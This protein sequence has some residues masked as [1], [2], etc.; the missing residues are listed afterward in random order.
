MSPGVFATTSWS[1]LQALESQLRVFGGYRTLWLDEAGHRV[2]H[3]EPDEALESEG[4]TYVDTVLH[5]NAEELAVLL[6]VVPAAE[7]PSS[8][9]SVDPPATTVVPAMTPI[10]A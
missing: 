1:H 10:P 7:S 8:P 3:A 5:P 4:L 6:G 2:V 9:A